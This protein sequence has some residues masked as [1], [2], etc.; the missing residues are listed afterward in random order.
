M[1]KLSLFLFVFTIGLLLS[2]C[3]D[4]ESS[5]SA[6]PSDST[7]KIADEQ[8]SWERI[9]ESGKIVVGTEGLYFPVT[10]FDENTQ[11]L[12]GFDVEVA[13][14][15]GKRLGLEVGFKTM[16]FDGLLPALRNG[17]IDVAANDFTITEERLEKFDFTIPIKHSFGSALVRE[18]DSSGIDTVEDLQGKKVGGSATSNYSD[19]AR[20]QGAEVVVYTGSDTVLPEIING[21]VDATLNDYLVLIQTLKQFNKPGLKLAENVKF[22]PNVGAIVMQKDSTELKNQLDK[23]LQEMIDDGSI[24]E[25]ALEFFGADVSHPVEID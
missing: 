20:S 21:R 16:E 5:S 2:A 8:N 3:G 11:E 14:E 22:E 15:L 10:Y 19:F 7:S 24:K 6:T 18:S 17:Q 23:V 12:T 1:K 9:K 4:N 13:K 25:I